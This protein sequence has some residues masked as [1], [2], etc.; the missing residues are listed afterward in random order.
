[1]FDPYLILG[2]PPTN[3][4][5]TACVWT[6]DSEESIRSLVSWASGWSVGPISL[7]MI[8]TQEPRSVS[9]QQLIERLKTLQ[10]HPSLSGL[11]LH[12]LHVKNN[13]HSPSAYLNLAR[14]FANSPTVLLFPAHL[15]NVP[16][17]FYEALNSHIHHPVR[18]P[19]L[20]TSTT[21]S[22][23][24]IPRL[25]PVVLPRNYRLWCTERAFLAS[26]ATEWDD[27]LWQLWFEEYGLGQANITITFNT[28]DPVGLDAD[29]S[30]LVSQKCPQEPLSN[31]SSKTRHLSGKYRAE[32]CEVAIKRL[33][34]DAPRMSKGAKR[35]LQWVKNFCRQVIPCAI[36]DRAVPL[37]V[38]HQTENATKNSGA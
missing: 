21:A 27:C 1:M 20:I 18:K 9:H 28:E 34:T 3:V 32:L 31:R 12:L 36:K 19:V 13:A 6:T 26:R 7:A 14:L 33:S 15:S 35:K 10:G 2:A 25:T 29:A 30:G 16:S 11:S 23:F 37:I 5:I 8:T 17:N 38:V 4:G 22:A 24:S